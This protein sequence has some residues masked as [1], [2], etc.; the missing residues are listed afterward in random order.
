MIDWLIKE[1]RNN[2]RDFMNYIAVHLWVHGWWLLVVGNLLFIV[3][4]PMPFWF[5]LFVNGTIGLVIFLSRFLA[6]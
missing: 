3:G 6:R 2:K 4:K 1:I 5:W